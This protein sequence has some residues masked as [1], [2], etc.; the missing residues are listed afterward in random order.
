VTSIKIRSHRRK[1][2]N[3]DS[4]EQKILLQESSQ[5]W[6][7]IH[8]YV[9]TIRFRW[10]FAANKKNVNNIAPRGAWSPNH[11]FV[12]FYVPTT[13]V[14][15][16]ICWKSSP[17]SEAHSARHGSGGPTPARFTRAIF[18]GDILIRWKNELKGQPSRTR[19]IK[20][21]RFRP[22]WISVRCMKI[23]RR[24]FHRIV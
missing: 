20:S 5:N 2:S 16:W 13:G 12:Q 18:G 10:S 19:I 17:N 14:L 21:C 1:F 4:V 9:K 24:S 23:E 8:N 11:Q 15:P 7:S 6:K 22:G 3:S